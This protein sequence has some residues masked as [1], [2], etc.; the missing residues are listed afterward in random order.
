MIDRP[1]LRLVENR[2]QRSVEAMV[3]PRAVVKA[4]IAP[5]G[6]Q[7]ELPFHDQCMG[8]SIVIACLEAMSGGRLRN[9]LVSHRPDA[10]VDLRELI[11]FDLP[12]T[13]RK[14]VFNTFRSLHARYVKDPLPWHQL[15]VKDLIGSD[16]PI[17]M[18]LL[19]EVAERDANCVMI[20][21]PR[22]DDRRHVAAHLRRIVPQR[23]SM[24]FR[25]EEAV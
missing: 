12:G 9:L 7:L 24:P 22:Q 16:Y 5:P 18:S 19:H 6:W 20:F 14:D 15:A 10:V 11:R 17:S 2:A 13:N 3:A 25:I 23:L 8:V 21:V 1:H 4:T